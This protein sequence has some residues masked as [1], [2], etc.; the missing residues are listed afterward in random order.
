LALL[1]LHLAETATRLGQTIAAVACAILPIYAGLLTQTD[2]FRVILVAA[3][4]IFVAL[5]FRAW[6]VSFEARITLRSAFSWIVV[7]ALPLVLVSAAPFGPSIA[8]EADAFVKEMWREDPERT[9]LK[10][11][12]RV[13]LW[14]QAIGRGIEAGM[15]GLGPGPHLEIP[16][17]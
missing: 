3:G 8:V 13:N 5:K 17:V 1:S 9:E 16:P 14:G 15:L 4:P 10:T 12:L 7:L 6:L 2:S 11:E